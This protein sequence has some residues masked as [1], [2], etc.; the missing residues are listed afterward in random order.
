MGRDRMV[1]PLRGLVKT[2]CQQE[3]DL[4]EVLRRGAAGVPKCPGPVPLQVGVTKQ[5]TVGSGDAGPRVPLR[6]P[7]SFRRVT[8]FEFPNCAA[9]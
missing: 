8:S 2:A 3:R 5:L 4:Q 9:T 1:R 7:A 6:H